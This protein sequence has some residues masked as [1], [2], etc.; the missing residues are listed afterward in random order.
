[1]RKDYLLP[2]LGMLLAGSAGASD[3]ISI[4]ASTKG[5]LFD[6]A[7]TAVAKVATNHGNLRSTLRNYASPNVFIPAIARGQVDFGIANQFEVMLAVT[8]QSYFEGRQQ[9]NLRAVAV[10]FPLQIAIFVSQDSTVRRIADLK[11]RRMP[12]GY[13]ANKIILPLIDA[14]LA[15]DGLTRSD[16]DSLNVP[17]TAA[18]ADAFISGRTE[19][20]LMALRAPK[21]REANARHGIRALPILNTRENLAAI[22]Q[23]MPVAYLALEQ[24]GPSN[25]GILEPTWIITYDTLLFAST[26][27]SDDAVYRLTRTL[28]ENRHQLVAASP[29]FRRFS[30]D[31]MAKDLGSVEYHAGAI[32]FYTEQGLWPPTPQ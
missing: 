8:G 22:R 21:V 26:E 10:L 29:A 30:Q 3:V 13:V 27:T 9:A 24:P 5:T 15:A 19:G 17:G 1:M 11:G 28:F 18:G 23:H 31:A 6:Q 20:F 4:A 16:I 7:G 2:M 12:D 14:S 25:P 32:R